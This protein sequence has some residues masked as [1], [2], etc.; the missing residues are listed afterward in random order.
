MF[1]TKLTAMRFQK[2]SLESQSV[3]KTKKGMGI[4]CFM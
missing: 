2:T 1:Y 3:D 4:L